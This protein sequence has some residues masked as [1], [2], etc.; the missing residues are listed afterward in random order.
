MKESVEVKLP[1]SLSPKEKAEIEVKLDTYRKVLKKYKLEKCD[2]KGYL[3]S[4]LSRNEEIGLSSLQARSKRGEIVI[5]LSDKTKKNIVT[6]PSLYIRMGEA[7]TAKDQEVNE[8]DIRRCQNVLYG[9]TSSWNKIFNRGE[10]WNQADRIRKSTL[11]KGEC[12]A[13]LSLLGK[14]HK[15]KNSDSSL[16]T[17][18]V[19][20]GDK[21]MGLHLANL[22]S[23]TV[24]SMADCII[25]SNE[26]VS[27]KD[28]LSNVGRYNENIEDIIEEIEKRENIKIDRKEE[29]MLIDAD[30][31]TTFPIVEAESTAQ[32]VKE[33]IKQIEV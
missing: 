4:N 3:Q 5:I 7:P 14:D 11:S 8:H 30:T 25:D 12:I 1:R 16:P 32:A 21:S 31:V 20:S 33:E 9:H 19:V 22:I 6:T 10:N 23:E 15:E 18:P 24:E 17:R 2:K 27:G 26:V 28:W 29:F 13:P